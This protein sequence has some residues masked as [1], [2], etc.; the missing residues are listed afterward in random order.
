MINA[1]AGTGW[2]TTLADLSIILF[3]VTASTL[4]QSEAAPAPQRVQASPQSQPL[5]VYRAE[6]GAPPL[7]EWLAGQSADVRQQLT[8]VAQF[9]PGHQA[10]ALAGA[11]ALAREAGEGG[12]RARIVV[13]PGT[14]GITASLAYD[15]PKATMVQP[16]AHSLQDSARHE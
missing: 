9:A 6:A 13:E 5:A 15:D 1:R 2:Q 10:E 7:R 3:M 4:S 11:E 12:T 14:D 8:I 16:L